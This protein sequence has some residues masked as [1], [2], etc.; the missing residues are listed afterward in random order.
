M[1][2][3]LIPTNQFS[4]EE[5]TEAYNQTRVDYMVPMPMNATRLREYIH[6]YDVDLAQ[7][8]VAVDDSH[9]QDTSRRAKRRIRAR[10]GFLPAL[11][12]ARDS[13]GYRCHRRDC[14]IR[15]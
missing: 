14:R 5:L 3:S 13:A 15:R 6:V 7:S 4:V 1:T 11:S 8:L 9:G 2:T 10:G 12:R